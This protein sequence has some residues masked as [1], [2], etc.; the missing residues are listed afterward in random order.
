[1]RG[2]NWMIFQ[3]VIADD[4]FSAESDRSFTKMSKLVNEPSQSF[5]L[6]QIACEIQPYLLGTYLSFA[7]WYC[8]L[9]LLPTF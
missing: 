5:P 1:M 2:A 4:K 6:K 3:D 7:I 9:M 8:H